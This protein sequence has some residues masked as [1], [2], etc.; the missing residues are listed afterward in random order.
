MRAAL[1]AAGNGDTI[2]FARSLANQTIAL[3]GSGPL[4]LAITKSVTITSGGVPGIVISGSNAATVFT[5]SSGVSATIDSL[6]IS[7]GMSQLSGPNGVSQGGGILNNGTLTV[8][9]CTLTGNQAVGGASDYGGGIANLGTLT[10][11]NSTIANNGLATNAAASSG[12]GGIFSSGTLTAIN[13]TI[14][15]NSGFGGSGGGL[16]VSGTST[17]ENTIVANNAATI[18]VNVAGTLTSA[19][20]DL[21]STSPNIASGGANLINTNPQLNPSGLQ[22]NGGPTQ[23][24]AEVQGGLSNSPGIGKGN[25]AFVTNP[26]FQG[27]PFFDQR[28]FGF[29]RIVVGFQTGSEQTD[30]G[31]IED[32][33]PNASVR[34]YFDPFAGTGFTGG[35]R[36][37]VG[38]VTGDGIPDLIVGSGPGGIG[39]VLVYDGASVLANPESPTLIGAFYPFGPTFRGGVYVAVAN[40]DGGTSDEIVVAADAGGGPEV[41]IY[42]PAQIQAHNY[43]NPAVGFF[44]YSPSFTGGVRLAV[45][46]VNGDGKDDLITAAGPSGG[47]EGQHLLRHRRRRLHRWGRAGDADAGPGVLRP[48]ADAPDLRGRHLCH[49]P[50]HQRRW[51]GRP[52]LWGRGR[53]L[54]GDALSRRPVDR[55]VAELQPAHRVLRALLLRVRGIYADVVYGGC[56]C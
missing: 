4:T 8:S 16:D 19:S 3:N 56:G 22:N 34:L 17:V 41:N 13:C 25:P 30:I 32:Q 7:N 47:P 37:A 5:V 21:F 44:A 12:G 6:T 35:T 49:R 50:G 39:V 55:A 1:A 42:S 36:V 23:T 45:G 27:P 20:N 14:V 29:S 9:A 43:A 31:A 40:L 2:D 24:I 48:G 38:D 26:P 53:F 10:I 15:N 51:Q 52:V 46:D 11:L 33:T 54:R 28:G 18:G